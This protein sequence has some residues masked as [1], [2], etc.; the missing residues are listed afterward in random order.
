MLGGLLSPR[1]APAELSGRASEDRERDSEHGTGNYGGNDLR[2]Q[3]RREDDADDEKDERRNP[4]I[5]PKLP[6]GGA[7]LTARGSAAPKASAAAAG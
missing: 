2:E 4:P 6:S 7:R 1:T 5:H 3:E